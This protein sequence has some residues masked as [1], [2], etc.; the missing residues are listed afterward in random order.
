M[1]KEGNTNTLKSIKSLR[2]LP[3]I[4]PAKKI[5]EKLKIRKEVKKPVVRKEVKTKPKEKKEKKEIEK[6]KK[7]KTWKIL[8][9]FI[10]LLII[11]IVAFIGISVYFYFISPIKQIGIGANIEE[12]L[13]SPDNQEVYIKLIGGSYENI[14]KIKFIFK[15]AEEEYYYET[16]EGAIE[17]NVEFK[18]SF[19]DWMF[20]R[21]KFEGTYEYKID[22][23]AVGL[24]DFYDIGEVSV[25]FEY[26]EEG[27]TVD[28]EILDTERTIII[29]SSGN[30]NGNGNGGP[31]PTTTCVPQ[32]RA[33]TCGDWICGERTNNCGTSVNCGTC[34]NNLTCQSGI[35]INESTNCTDYL[36]IDYYRK[37]Y[38]YNGT[39]FWDFCVNGNLTEYICECEDYDCVNNL[40]I[41]CE[42]S[43]DD[44]RCICIDECAG[45]GLGCDGDMSFNC[46]LNATT[47]CFE[48]ENLTDCGL[49]GE[50]CYNGE[51]HVPLECTH[52]DNCTANNLSGIETCD[53]I[54]DANPF[55][56]DYREAFTSKCNLSINICTIGDDTVTY[57]CDN[58][59]CGAECEAG[60][61]EAQGV[62]YCLNN[63][64]YESNYTCNASCFFADDL[65]TGN[66]IL[67]D[68]C[69]RTCSADGCYGDKYYRDYNDSSDLCMGNSC[70]EP[71]NC[72]TPISSVCDQ[73]CGANCDEDGDCP[74]AQTCDSNCECSG[75]VCNTHDDCAGLGDKYCDDTHSCVD[76]ILDGGECDSVN[77]PVIDG[78]QSE[79]CQSNF[80]HID[81]DGGEFCVSSSTSCTHNGTEYNSGD[82]APD[83]FSNN[84][85]RVCSSG[86][87][88]AGTACVYNYF[89]YLG[90]CGWQYH[91]DI[92]VDGIVEGTCD[93]TIDGQTDCNPYITFEDNTDCYSGDVQYCDES[94]G[95]NCDDNE[96]CLCPGDICIDGD[97]DGYFDDF[98]NYSDTSVCLNDCSCDTC[99]PVITIDDYDNCPIHPGL[100]EDCGF[101]GFFCDRAE[102][103]GIVERCYFI[104]RLGPNGCSP[105]PP[106][107]CTGYDGDNDTCIADRCGLGNCEWYIDTCRIEPVCGDNICEPGEDCPQDNVSCT[108]NVCYEPACTDG[109]G[110]VAVPAYENDEACLAINN[111]FCNGTGSCVECL[112]AAD[113]DDLNVCTIDNCVVG[114][115]SNTLITQCSYYDE[116]SQAECEGNTCGLNCEWNATSLQ[117][118]SLGVPEEIPVSSCDTLNSPN[119]L[120]YLTQ[121][122]VHNLGWNCIVINARN[123]TLDCKGHSITT[124]SSDT[125]SGI[126]SN[127]TNTTIKNCNISGFQ[128]RS[129]NLERANNSYVFNNMI[130]NNLI[131]LR[132]FESSGIEIINNTI[133]LNR[134]GLHI[135]G[136]FG[137][138][139]GNI[140]QGNTICLNDEDVFCSSPQTFI[141]NQCETMS[142]CG[143]TCLPCP[144]V[145]VCSD[146]DG[147]INYNVKGI[148]TDDTNYPGGV[149]DYC[150]N[151]NLREYFC[152][153]ELG[154]P[155]GYPQCR[156]G[157]VSVPHTCGPS[158][159]VDDECVDPADEVYGCQILNQPN[160]VYR[161]MVDFEREYLFRM[162]CIIIAAE[163]IT[164]DCQGYSITDDVTNTFGSGIYSNQ[165]N[166]TIKNCNISG[167][168]SGTSDGFG[169]ELQ[170]ADNSYIFNNTLTD[171]LYGLLVET[172]S[173]MQIINNTINLNQEK[174]I[175]VIGEGTGNIIQGN[176]FCWNTEDAYCTY[177][178]F[179]FDNTCDVNN[180]CGGTCNPCVLPVCGD[181]N[182]GVGEQCDGSNLSGQTCE[183][184]GFDGGNLSCYPPGHVNQCIFNTSQ[185]TALAEIPVS[186][187]QSLTNANSYYYLTQ[188]IIQTLSQNCITITAENI[189]FDCEGSSITSSI[190]GISGI[191]SNMD[192]ITIKNCD[193]NMYNATPLT[194]GI[195]LVGSD[196]SKVL[197]N[198]LKDSWTALAFSGSNLQI[199]NNFV[200]FTLPESIHSSHGIYSES[201]EVN[202]LMHNNE[203]YNAARAIRFAGF[204]NN[205]T[206]NTVM[207]STW[208]ISTTGFPIDPAKRSE[209]NIIANN[210]VKNN[211]RG[212]QLWASGCRNN[213]ILNNIVVSNSIGMYIDYG[214]GNNLTG[215]SFCYNTEYDL[216]CPYAQIFENNECGDDGGCGGT[217]NACTVLPTSS[218]WRGIIEFF[219]SLY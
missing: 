39:I 172:S 28:T 109:C 125:I 33:E 4:L 146:T 58:S 111:E 194:F 136:W 3:S 178:Q 45:E 202:N 132:V 152:G 60:E 13:V 82:N 196:Y 65:D 52:N 74:G 93:L 168:L 27:E 119:S 89:D 163:N 131:G 164:F 17:I 193:I 43:C 75:D 203:I 187:C 161:Q 207:F 76:R 211:T 37:D 83:C 197:N 126:Y 10:I 113:C 95:A 15:S 36:G 78:N 147:G 61:S 22:A 77:R 11:G 1:K 71:V 216:D 177:S 200:N 38:V 115:C 73:G 56:W 121:D 205:I 32:S 14:T 218:L 144:E 105:C 162:D 199:I 54:P 91:D 35:C 158:G 181:N 5:R 20:G 148:C 31:S 180:G 159:C 90:I 106:A 209:F 44:G 86:N 143:G 88:I 176:E 210:Y 169:I 201:Y 117:C 206:N 67:E 215:N 217:C 68:N 120:Y 85:E 182:I 185:C 62:Y 116:T 141:D 155:A 139:T 137:I 102:C 12:A 198:T 81:Y 188:D 151:G 110:Q 134:D 186:F 72:T 174:G 23:E 26:E 130:N 8:K 157:S 87:W 154:Y 184:F 138:S 153:A 49:T 195:K 135:N 98:A 57:T 112:I 212:I 103:E 70:V 21:P 42:L 128:G 123:I 167:F 108:D 179:I 171:N 6:G 104:D 175:Y 150:V 79:V 51:C 69:D 127:Q 173:D 133:T 192:N 189:I 64:L 19:W 53:N 124:T 63:N 18:R 129:I 29:T 34:L 47:G 213:T 24:P 160:T 66:D 166:T 55:T 122:I 84:Q 7:P 219:K 156:Y 190:G 94:C 2:E 107:D 140:V 165:V 40:T 204:Y 208:G 46:S 191:F 59:T 101:F 50:I 142:N 96:D 118:E 97:L 149:S 25:L 100:C 9:I 114:V 16:S 41:E 145:H 214:T 183:S 99:T 170:G 80:C 92:C 48:R 30:G